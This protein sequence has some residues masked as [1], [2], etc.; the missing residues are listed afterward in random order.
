[1]CKF[2]KIKTANQTAD[3]RQQAVDGFLKEIALKLST[4]FD[5]Q[6]VYSKNIVYEPVTYILY[7]QVD[8]I[9]KCLADVAN[10]FKEYLI[11]HG[12]TVKEC[13]WDR[14]KNYFRIE[15]V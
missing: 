3:E 7:Q 6:V 1:M 13:V 2:N 8:G 4:S 14:N 12:Y 15:V 10:S 5:D 9:V 11:E